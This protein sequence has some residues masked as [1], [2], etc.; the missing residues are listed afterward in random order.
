MRCELIGPGRIDYYV[1]N[2]YA[3]LID[4]RQEELY[5]K[6]H[7]KGAYNW[8]FSEINTFEGYRKFCE[9]F[10]DKM[11]VYVIYCDMGVNSLIV[12]NNLS[13]MGYRTKSLVG[14]MS[15]Y[16]GTAIITGDSHNNDKGFKTT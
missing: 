8:P 3:I 16:K 13:S 11:L 14:G 15:G 6:S 10:K 7:I 4:V 9:Y 12:G 1:H 2:P 5:N